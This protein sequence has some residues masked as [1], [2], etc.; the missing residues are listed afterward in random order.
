MFWCHRCHS[1]CAPTTYRCR[2]CG[3]PAAA[4]RTTAILIGCFALSVVLIWMMTQLF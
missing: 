3:A 1:T 2:V 4:G